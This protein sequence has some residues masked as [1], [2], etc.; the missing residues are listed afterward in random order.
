MAQ[1]FKAILPNLPKDLAEYLLSDAR[2][3]IIEADPSQPSTN[4]P[5]LPE[6]RPHRDVFLGEL[7]HYLESICKGESREFRIHRN[8]KIRLRYL[9]DALELPY[10]ELIIDLFEAEMS[11]K[12]AFGISQTIMDNAVAGCYQFIKSH[13]EQIRNLYANG[14][15]KEAPP[16]AI[17]KGIDLR[18][19]VLKQYIQAVDSLRFMDAVISITTD[20]EQ[21]ETEV[22]EPVPED[23]V[24]FPIKNHSSP[25]P[26]ILMQTRFKSQHSPSSSSAWQSPWSQV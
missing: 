1:L 18:L 13:S 12:Q 26:S 4:D 16:K 17:L 6:T 2:A 5:P 15:I 14:T 20:Q 3:V 10:W 25:A 23:R 22:E 19:G 24:S 7:G 21:N 11:S 9:Q 8:G